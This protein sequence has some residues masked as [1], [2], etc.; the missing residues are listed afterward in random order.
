MNNLLVE[1]FKSIMVYIRNFPDDRDLSQML[2]ALKDAMQNSDN[3][4]IVLRIKR[5]MKKMIHWVQ[6]ESVPV[7]YHDSPMVKQFLCDCL[8]ILLKA[9]EQENVQLIYDLSD[10]LQG[11]PDLKFWESSKNM[12]D[13]WE[14]YVKPVKKKWKLNRL[15]R[16]HDYLLEMLCTVNSRL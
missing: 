4:I 1:N 3:D 11:I 14:I 9:E 6:E 10:M 16:Y 7:E 5:N 13:Y 12:Q 15:D 8:E 2:F